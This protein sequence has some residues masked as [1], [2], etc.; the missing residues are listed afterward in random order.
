MTAANLQRAR[1]ASDQ[2]TLLCFPHAGGTAMAYGH[3]ANAMP[4]TTVIPVELPGRGERIRERPLDSMDALIIEL[5]G[6][7]LPHVGGQFALFGHSMGALI[8]FE[9]AHR[10]RRQYGLRPAH[11][12]VSGCGA[13]STSRPDA[14]L[15]HLL[16][17]DELWEQVRVL[18]GTPNGACD[19]AE[20]R[21]LCTGAV[22]ADFALVENYRFGGGTPLD[23]PI[24]VFHG[25][26]DPEV[27]STELEA[28]ARHTS[29]VYTL[30]TFPGDHFYL[31]RQPPGFLR[32]VS[33]ELAATRATFTLH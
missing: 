29:S 24:S 12:L 32:V 7:L 2:L 21:R 3:W 22:R 13:P 23:C 25:V 33:R 6:T 26:D 19:N 18:N 11:L 28:W 20:I 1:R 27:E 5:T 17:D 4:T 31:H 15:R 10:L 16:P 9:L 14:P 30:S 8:A